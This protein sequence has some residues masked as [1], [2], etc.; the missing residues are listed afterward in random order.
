MTSF[1]E[2]S[3]LDEGWINGGF[4]VIN[5]KFFKYIRNDKTYLEREPLEQVTKV[6]SYLLL[7]IR[8]L[9]MHGH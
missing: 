2:K 4:F 5:P 3:S 6:N 7:N 1:R 8:V 9:A